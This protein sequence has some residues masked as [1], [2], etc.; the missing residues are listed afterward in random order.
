MKITVVPGLYVVAVS[1]GVDSMVLLDV[2]QKDPELRLIV[3][4]LDHGIRED[5]KQDRELVGRVASVYGL[6]FE[7]REAKLRPSVSEADARNGSL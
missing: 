5:S 1:G 7:Y 4:H 3:A 2:L 6:P